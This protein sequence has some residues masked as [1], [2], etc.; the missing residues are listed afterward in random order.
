ME[1]E[2][3]YD[4]PSEP[5]EPEKPVVWFC[6]STKVKVLG[7]LIDVTFGSRPKAWEWEGEWDLV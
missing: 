1:K 7:E 6:P 3:F 2:K 5:E 4:R